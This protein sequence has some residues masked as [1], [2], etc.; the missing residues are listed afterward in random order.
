VRRDPFDIFAKDCLELLL[1]DAG[2]VE[3]SHEVVLPAQFIDATFSPTGAGRAKLRSRGLLGKLARRR[4]AWECFHDAPTLSDLRDVARKHL[5]WHHHLTLRARRKDRNREVPLP[6]LYVVCAAR[7]TEAME[8]LLATPNPEHG[9][10]LYGV[11]L[12]LVGMCVIVVAE[13]PKT[14]ATLP[15]RLLGRDAVL[16]EALAEVAALPASR[17]E[18]RI[19]PA[20]IELMKRRAGGEGSDAMGRLSALYEAREKARRRA[21]EKRA[22]ERARAAETKGLER[23]LER[24]LEKGLEKGLEEGLEKGRSEVLIPVV[25]ARLGRRLRR[26]EVDT[27]RAKVSTLGPTRTA[28]VVVGREPE[29]LAAWLAGQ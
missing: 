10:G 22:R 6:D 27:L 4:C 26:A 21:E 12:A 24:G 11:A 2:R 3:R 28:R 15:L 8:R 29:A 1:E 7:P 20:M 5:A 14:K 13:L 18:H 17:W 25:E 19:Q 23:G 9:D 16:E